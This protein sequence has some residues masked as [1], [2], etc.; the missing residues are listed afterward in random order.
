MKGGLSHLSG[1]FKCI[2]SRFLRP[3]FYFKGSRRGHVML[4]VIFIYENVVFYAWGYFVVGMKPG[5]QL[6]SIC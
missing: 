1:C 4:E 6:I 3:V 5:M 2:G